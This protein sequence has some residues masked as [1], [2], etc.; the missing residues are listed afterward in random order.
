METVKVYRWEKL[1]GDRYIGPLSAH[2][3]SD[4][5]DLELADRAI[6]KGLKGKLDVNKDIPKFHVGML[7]CTDSFE[8]LN[9]WVDIRA[10]TICLTVGFEIGVYEVPKDKLLVGKQQSAFHPDNAKRLGS[11]NYLK[12]ALEHYR[13][14]RPERIVERMEKKININLDRCR[15]DVYEYTYGWFR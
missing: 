8:Q 12:L 1:I 9:K 13:N 6:R 5:D 3:Y 7:C 2:H 14:T 11:A 10:A 15:K 4:C